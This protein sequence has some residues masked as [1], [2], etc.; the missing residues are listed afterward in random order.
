MKKALQSMSRGSNRPWRA[1][2]APACGFGENDRRLGSHHGWDAG[3]QFLGYDQLEVEDARIVKYRS[4]SNRQGNTRSSD[5]TPS[6]RK[7]GQVGDTGFLSTAGR[8]IRVEDTVRE[9]DLI[10]HVARADA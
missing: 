6:I 4:V 9:N 7:E 5:R 8:I 10:I 2:K 3:H 1:Q